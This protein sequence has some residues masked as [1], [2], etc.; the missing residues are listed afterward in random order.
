MTDTLSG[1]IAGGVT[2]GAIAGGFGAQPDQVVPSESYRNVTATPEYMVKIETGESKSTIENFVDHVQLFHFYYKIAR[3]TNPNSGNQLFTSARATIED[4]VMVIPNGNLA[5]IIINK[6]LKGD[7][8]P[9]IHVVRLANIA[10]VNVIA[11]EL[12]FTNNFFQTYEPRYDTVIVSF[13]PTIFENKINSYDRNG[14]N[15]GSTS[16][17]FDFTTAKL[18]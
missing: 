4:P 7:L 13:K 18:V 11:Q 2:T 16:V 8:I 5:P 10:Q 17:K 14:K 15:T 3:L 9:T 12:T 6:L 1:G